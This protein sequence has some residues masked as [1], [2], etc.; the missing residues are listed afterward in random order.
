MKAQI[1]IALAGFALLLGT[2]P[3]QAFENP[4]A[5]EIISRVRKSVI[6]IAPVSI[7]QPVA[8][9]FPGGGGSGV[10]FQIDYDEGT[11]YALTNHHVS[12]DAMINGV[13]FWNGAEYQ[14]ELVATEPGIDT[15]LLLLKGIPDERDLPDS[16]KTI[17]AAVLGDSDATRIG[18]ISIAMGSPGA[19]EGFNANRDD[20]YQDSMLQ[21]TAT[22]GVVSGKEGDPIV[23]ASFW[24]GWRDQQG[25]Q[26]M[27]NT[28][29]SFKVVVPINSGNS[30]GPLFN[31]RGEVI[32]LN[33]AGAD[34]DGVRY[35]NH[36][37]TIP[38]N[39]SKNFA[40][41]ILNT[42]KYEVPW[43]GLDM[44]IPRNFDDVGFW[45]AE[46]YDPTV[47]KIIGVRPNSPASRAGLLDEDLILEFDGQVFPTLLALRQHVFALPIGKQV[48][49]SVQ[50][51]GK[52]VHLTVEVAPKRS[53]D[54]ELSL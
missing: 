18:E 53:Y 39:L 45:E 29:W 51:S 6:R 52:K 34:N 44:I 26:V 15:A 4:Q 43:L 30:G 31:S 22:M 40:Y 37:W 5:A 47:L 49:I 36:N 50:R 19:Y 2:L 46:H 17:I 41:Q 9:G 23:F 28:P 10:V 25:H 8:F 12:G 35:Q 32:G 21:Q 42:G 20:P 38:I 3:V 27:T 33:H 16:E 48:P 24:S 1:I 7:S 13:R 54:S 11:A 14:A